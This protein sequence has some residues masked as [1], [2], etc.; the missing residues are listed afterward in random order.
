MAYAPEPE[1]KVD[2]SHGM[3][4]E[5]RTDPETP[6]PDGLG[7]RTGS[8]RFQ[9]SPKIHHYHPNR[10]KKAW[11]TAFAVIA[12]SLVVHV[13]GWMGMLYAPLGVPATF[14][15]GVTLASV[16]VIVVT[17][18]VYFLYMENLEPK[19]YRHETPL[20]P[21]QTKR[22]DHKAGTTRAD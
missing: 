3:T 10:H 20:R 1:R 9:W 12:V 18:S 14:A 19:N 8:N 15:A 11:W 5:G 2:T 17:P 13:S 16:L 7:D 6:I 22:P 21:E 4:K